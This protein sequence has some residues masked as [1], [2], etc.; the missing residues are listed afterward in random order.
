MPHRIPL[1]A[2]ALSLGA[3]SAASAQDSARTASQAV[4]TSGQVTQALTESGVPA[5]TALSVGP[6]VVAGG[7]SLVGASMIAS[8]AAD[9]TAAQ[10]RPAAAPY[11]RGPLPV[12]DTVVVAQPAPHVPYDAPAK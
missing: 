6:A 2:L 5:A 9:S 3:A 7:V 10:T 11:G 12:G 4:N 8:G 1:A